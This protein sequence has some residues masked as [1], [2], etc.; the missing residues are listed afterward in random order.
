MNVLRAFVTDND[1]KSHHINVHSHRAHS[2]LDG[3]VEADD[4]GEARV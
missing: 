3:E 4:W 2:Y 1:C